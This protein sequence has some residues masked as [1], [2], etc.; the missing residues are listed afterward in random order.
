M[1]EHITQE[2][3]AHLRLLCKR[4]LNLPIDTITPLNKQTTNLLYLI[5]AEQRKYIL[6]QLNPLTW[7]G[8]RTQQEITF[9]ESVTS[10]VAAQ[11]K[12]TNAALLWQ[13]QHYLIPELEKWYILIPFVEGEIC[14]NWS[15]RQSELLGQTL[16]LIHA[17]SLPQKE[18]KPFPKLNLDQA[19]MP[20][21]WQ[22]RV[23]RINENRFH[24]FEEWV[25]SHRDLHAGNVIWTQESI[26]HL[27]DWE[28]IGLIHPFVDL[29]GLALNAAEIPMCRFNSANFCATLEGYRIIAGSLPKEDTLLWEQCVHSWLLWYQY[30][31][32][33]KQHQEAK[34]TMMVLD[35]IDDHFNKM[36]ELYLTRPQ[37]LGI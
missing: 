13:G 22:Q 4:Y 35:L 36:K 18:A 20:S 15:I 33:R 5:H 34:D 25:T 1:I 28:S 2:E 24:R 9:S 21:R 29:V 7:L 23:E 19:L 32:D 17:S 27:I 26:P 8:K 12:N 31:L 37:S 11:L 3:E 30:S 10:L 16:A 14:R 6:K